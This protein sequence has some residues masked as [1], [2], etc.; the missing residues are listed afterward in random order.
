MI[1]LAHWLDQG[2]EI[3][4]YL[5]VSNIFFLLYIKISEENVTKLLQGKTVVFVIFASEYFCILK[6]FR[7][8]FLLTFQ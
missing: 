1:T 3:F 8:T 4:L 2:R 5:S 7:K 6:L